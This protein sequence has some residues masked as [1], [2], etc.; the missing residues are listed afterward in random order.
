MRTLGNEQLTTQEISDKLPDVP[1]SSIY[2][3]LKL[4]LEGDLVAIADSRLVNGIQEKVYKLIHPPALDPGDI[5]QLSA[6]DHVRYFSTYALMLIQDFAGYVTEAETAQGN[7][8]M[9]SDRSGYR[10][11]A[12]YATP[13]ELDVAIGAI[14]QALLPLI[15]QEAG[16]GRRR[17]KLA[18]VLHPQKD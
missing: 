11:V 8:D 6:E 4:L 14:N 13:L 5:A 7:I 15:Q 3:H 18:T 12:F 17:Y 2:R 10:E 9:L 16:N 1:K